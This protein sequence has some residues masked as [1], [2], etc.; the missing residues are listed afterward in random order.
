MKTILD[1]NIFYGINLGQID[2]DEI[3]VQ[4][5]VVTNSNIDEFARS[6]NVVYSTERVRGSLRKAFE[7]SGKALIGRNPYMYILELDGKNINLTEHD[8]EIIKLTEMVAQGFEVTEENR[9]YVLNNWIQPREQELIDIADVFNQWFENIKSDKNFDLKKIKKEE[10]IEYLKEF[11]DEN[12]RNWTRHHLGEEIG[13]SNTFK[14]NRLE[15]FIHAF[16]AF[17]KSNLS[18]GKFKPH[19]SYDLNQLIYVQ[20]GDLFWT[21]EKKWQNIIYEQAKKGEYLKEYR[22][23]IIN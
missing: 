11:L 18:G 15:L 8:K 12:I 3:E 9:D 20:P 4:N 22:K 5:P 10:L 21:K 14:W 17:F 19:D 16:A 13:V 2:I 6:Y 1:N 23:E 7:L